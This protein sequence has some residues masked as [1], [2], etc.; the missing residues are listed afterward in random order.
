ML[1][2]RIR[3]KTRPSPDIAWDWADESNNIVVQIAALEQSL[4]ESE[5][6]HFQT[7]SISED[8]LTHTV[9]MH[10]TSVENYV[11][12]EKQLF[13]LQCSN[14]DFVNGVQHML[15]NGLTHSASYIFEK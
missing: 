2:K 13:D 10:F 3:I 8:G 6:L 14:G 9:E 12:Y 5:V 4:I 7:T 15:D 11:N 1:I